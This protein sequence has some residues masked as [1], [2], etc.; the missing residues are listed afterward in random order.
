MGLGTGYVGVNDFWEYDPTSNIWTKKADFNR[1]KAFAVGFSINGKGYIGTGVS[2]T[3]SQDGNGATKD[4]WEYDPAADTWTQKADFGGGTRF[5][6]TGFSIG[7]KGYIGTGEAFYSQYTGVS[8]P[9]KDFWEYDLGSS[10]TLTP[11]A[12]RYSLCPHYLWLPVTI[13]A[14]A[15]NSD[16]L[17]V[18]LS[19]QVTCNESARQGWDWTKPVINQKTG[20]IALLLLAVPSRS[21]TERKYTITITG[22]D[23]AGNSTTET[24]T[25]VVPRSCR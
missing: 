19:A 8:G 25:I 4:F 11:S 18:K 22:T 15:V 17:P 6:A 13:R 16:G 23:T 21:A 9:K 14:N 24:V 7:S 5:W 1:L 12:N 20:T 10:I 3:V 2:D